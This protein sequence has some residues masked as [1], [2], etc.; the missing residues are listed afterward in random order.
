[1]A[2]HGAFITGIDASKENINI[3]SSTV[4]SPLVSSAVMDGSPFDQAALAGA[5]LLAALGRN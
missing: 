3:A 1:M 4:V 5:N 2:N